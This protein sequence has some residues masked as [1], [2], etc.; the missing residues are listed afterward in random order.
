MRHGNSLGVDAFSQSDR[1]TDLVS[2]DVICVVL[3]ANTE[4]PPTV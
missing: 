2:R 1:E 3:N 4:Y